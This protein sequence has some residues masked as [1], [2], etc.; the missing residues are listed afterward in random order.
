MFKVNNKDT[1]TNL[2][3]HNRPPSPQKNKNKLNIIQKAHSFLFIGKSS[4]LLVETHLEGCI[5][6]SLDWS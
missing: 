4:I 5:S 6:G 3:N 1:R 2:H